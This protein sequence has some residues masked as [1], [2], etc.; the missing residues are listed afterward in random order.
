YSLEFPVGWRE[1]VLAGGHLFGQRNDLPLDTGQIL[2]EDLGDHRR[3]IGAKARGATEHSDNRWD[4]SVH[5]LLLPPVAAT[6]PPAAPPTATTAIAIFAPLLIP[7]VFTP[8]PG[9]DG[10]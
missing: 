7:P 4:D 10:P 5:R 8:A 2:V 1:A 3:R 9:V 6:M